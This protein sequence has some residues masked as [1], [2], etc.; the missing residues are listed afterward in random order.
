MDDTGGGVPRQIH[1]ILQRIFRPIVYHE[2]L[3]LSH[4]YGLRP[5]RR[6][7]P[8]ETIQ[9]RIASTNHYATA[10]ARRV[11]QFYVRL[12]LREFFSQFS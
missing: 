9:A 1:K 7:H 6:Q 8:R 12:I 5:Q 3:P 2:Q 10:N 4:G 11:T